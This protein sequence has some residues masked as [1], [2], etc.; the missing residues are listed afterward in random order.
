MALIKWVNIGLTGGVKTKAPSSDGLMPDMST[1]TTDITKIVEDSITFNVST[2]DNFKI[3]PQDMS[4]PWYVGNSGTMEA[5][6]NLQT[7]NYD[8]SLLVLAF[9][10]TASDENAVGEND[11]Y[12]APS[13]GYD[14]TYKAIKVSGDTVDGYY[15]NLEIPKAAI[16][17][18]VNSQFGNT[19]GNVEF[20]CEV[21]TPEDATGTLTPPWYISAEAS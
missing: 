5:I 14:L 8:P 12:A 19:A 18:N 16:R 13:A 4:L 11:T 9:G 1:G 15:V 7:Y 20:V 6:L 21:T 2:E 3:N 10:G 17:G